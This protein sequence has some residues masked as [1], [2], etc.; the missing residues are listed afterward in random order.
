MI[1]TPRALALALSLALLA[2]PGCGSSGDDDEGGG[3]TQS[4]QRA[5]P[6]TPAGDRQ[7][8]TPPQQR[9]RRPP[10]AVA[11]ARKRLEKA[12]FHVIV[13]SVDGVRPRPAGALELPLDRG[14]Q[15]TIFAYS[16]PADAK[17]KAA[18][19]AT[20]ARRY[21]AFYRVTVKGAT[22]YVGSAEQPERLDRAGF[23]KVVREADAR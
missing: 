16:D 2:G 6:V 1:A 19:F 21:P 20:L 10:A 12:G 15:V 3:P 22:A 7:Q 13:S 4:R 8:A 11:P 17:A 23:E 5:A 9:G 14:G 18:E